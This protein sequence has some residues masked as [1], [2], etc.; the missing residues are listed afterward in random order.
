MSVSTKRSA[1]PQ[2]W[3]TWVVI[4]SVVGLGLVTASY[5]IRQLD[6]W[7][8]DATMTIGFTLLLLGPVY[9]LTD[10]IEVSTKQEIE[11]VRETLSDEVGGLSSEVETLRR[12]V[13]ES[14]QAVTHELREREHAQI[15]GVR[16][17]LD[18]SSFDAMHQVL[19][20]ALEQNLVG[21]CGVRGDL[22]MTEFYLRIQ[23]DGDRLRVHLDADPVASVFEAG[24]RPGQGL[25]QVMLEL[26]DMVKPTHYWPGVEKWEFASGV[27]AIVNLLETAIKLR[28]QGRGGS[29]LVQ[30]FEG[31]WIFSD[32]DVRAI[33]HFYQ[34][35]YNRLDEMGWY[36]HLSG[37]SWV[38]RD[39]L[40]RMLDTAEFLRDLAKA[41]S[42]PAP[43]QPD[44][45]K[46]EH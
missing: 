7:W 9:W 6:G 31:E 17:L 15:E 42:R 18:D 36:K 23:P 43:S 14:Q 5:F 46:S 30:Q 45:A 13:E 4:P 41:E 2:R 19:S 37:K 40:E 32:W 25:E 29:H 1:A 33:P 39:T 8:S 27:K 38:N 21:P 44:E 16:R 12:T 3:I 22:P 34:I 10:R 35:T 24:W 11:S 26:A 20:E 28:A